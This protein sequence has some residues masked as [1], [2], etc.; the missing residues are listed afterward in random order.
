MQP[1]TQLGL[2][3]GAYRT[4]GVGGS[5]SLADVEGAARRMRIWPDPKRVPPTPWDVPALGP[6][7]RSR[8]DVDRAVSRLQEPTSRL[9]ERLLWYAGRRPP[10]AG[11]DPASTADPAAASDAPATNRDDPVAARHDAAVWALHA[12]IVGDD[13]VAW[14]RAA[15]RIAEAIRDP[16]YAGWLSRADA[17]AGFDKRASAAEASAALRSVAAGVAGALAA[18]SEAATAN[19]QSDRC[20]ALAALLRWF[21]TPA[22]DAGAS[23]DAAKATGDTSA[24][25]GAPAST[26]G[27]ARTQLLN[28]LEDDLLTRCYDLFNR[29]NKQLRRFEND[30]AKTY[31]DNRVH[32]V[33]AWGEYDM[34]IGPALDR[35]TELADGDRARTVRVRG[36][37][38]DLLRLIGIGWEWSGQFIRAEEMLAQATV[39]ADDVPGVTVEIGVV[40]KRVRPLAEKE[41]AAIAKAAAAAEASVL[42]IDE[43]A[44]AA[45]AGEVPGVYWIGGPAAA[46][47]T[48]PARKTTTT[49]TTTSKVPTTTSTTKSTPTPKPAGKST[50]TPTVA[51]VAKSLPIP[52]ATPVAT[53]VPS[54]TVTTS[55]LAVPTSTNVFVPYRVPPPIHSPALAAALAPPPL[56]SRG[57]QADRVLGLSRPSWLAIAVVGVFGFAVYAQTVLRVIW[58]TTTP[59]TTNAPSRPRRP[60]PP[61]PPPPDPD[62]GGQSLVEWLNGKQGN[63]PGDP[64]TAASPGAPAVAT[65]PAGADKGAD[66]S[67]RPVPR[68]ANDQLKR[69]TRREP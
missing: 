49:T 14:E 56:A 43:A 20:L 45:A 21:E 68:S 58:D 4:L 39:L 18:K 60:I 38:A 67:G 55:T 42:S 35:L 30:P 53:P 3:G 13:P 44:E 17:A 23:A 9:V 22:G 59:T 31:S 24:V 48:P 34:A 62:L 40:L 36:E 61:P 47:A 12:A 66:L 6:L 50:P 65:R 26:P 52:T 29:L 16:A 1:I 7:S 41:R 32:T 64:A 54:P 19:G 33:E 69:D 8:A 28:R 5:A 27:A 15:R 37:C 2:A 46:A 63:R 57:R 11:V 10:D 51:P 25:A